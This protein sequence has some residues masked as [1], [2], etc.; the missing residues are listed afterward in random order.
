M[1]SETLAGL[2]DFRLSG[3]CCVGGEQDQARLVDVSSFSSSV[4]IEV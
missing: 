1:V 3:D 4:S 2:L